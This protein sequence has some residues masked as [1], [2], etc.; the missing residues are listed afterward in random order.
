MTDENKTAK[1]DKTIEELEKRVGTFTDK[2][3]ELFVEVLGDVLESTKP[4]AEPPAAPPEPKKN[5]R[6]VGG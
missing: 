5:L 1:Q 2:L 4:K 6:I 3:K